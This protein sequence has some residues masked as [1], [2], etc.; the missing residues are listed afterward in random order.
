MPGRQNAWVSAGRGEKRRQDN[1]S[2]AGGTAR[3]P[4]G[5]TEG[6]GGQSR[7][8]RVFQGETDVET[9]PSQNMPEGGLPIGN[10]RKDGSIKSPYLS[11][12]GSICASWLAQGKKVVI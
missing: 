6:G 9:S 5:P 2:E 10:V 12:I 1:N 7:E 8:T 11:L 4:R 3:K